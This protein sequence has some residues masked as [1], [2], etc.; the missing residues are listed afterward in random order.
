MRKL[1]CKLFNKFNWVH[2]FKKTGAN[3]YGVYSR[4]KFCGKKYYI[5]YV[6]LIDTYREK[7]YEYDSYDTPVEHIFSEMDEPVDVRLP[8]NWNK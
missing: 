3:Q 2:Q 4:C 7:N 5:S 8:K 1:L 6:E